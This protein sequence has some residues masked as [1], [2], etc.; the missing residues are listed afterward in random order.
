[1][2]GQRANAKRG[3]LFEQRRR[4]HL[5]ALDKVGEQ[6]IQVVQILALHDGTQLGMDQEAQTILVF[7]KHKQDDWR[8]AGRSRA[9]SRR[10][11][12]QGAERQ[13]EVFAGAVARCTHSR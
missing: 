6:R 8:D 13:L 3:H 9:P 12:L 4:V 1:M 5:A 11:I 7:P 2:G 10:P